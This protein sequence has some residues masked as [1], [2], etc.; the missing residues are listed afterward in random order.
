MKRFY[1]LAYSV[2]P[3]LIIILVYLYYLS[4]TNSEQ[5]REKKRVIKNFENELKE[6][7]DRFEDFLTNYINSDDDIYSYWVQSDYEGFKEVLESRVVLGDDDPIK[8][9]SFYDRYMIKRA[10]IVH[11]KGISDIKQSSYLPKVYKDYKSCSTFEYSK[12]NGLIYSSI[13]PVFRGNTL[14]YVLEITYDISVILRKVYNR[15]NIY[16]L[17]WVK[18][19]N[20]NDSKKFIADYTISVDHDSKLHINSYKDKIHGYL[21]SDENYGIDMNSIS[22]F[23]GY[24]TK[25]ISD[26]SGIYVG[27]FLFFKDTEIDSSFYLIVVLVTIFSTMLLLI[28][29]Y[30]E[31][32]NRL[33]SDKLNRTLQL[34]HDKI[35]SLEE[36][37]QRLTETMF[38]YKELSN[39]SF[40]AIIF[41]ENAICVSA[42][43][44]AAKYFG[45][46]D[47]E[48]LGRNI[49]KF[50]DS[51]Y[52]D[53]VKK[54]I[55]ENNENPY[56]IE[57]RRKDGSTF[58]AHVRGRNIELKGKTLRI[59]AI[60]D[61]DQQK[62]NEEALRKAIEFSEKANRAKSEFL[63]N[64]S[65]EVRTPMNQVI[66]F[67]DIL[68]GSLKSE[69]DKEYVRN[70][71]GGG[72]KLLSIIDDIIYLSKL[73][74]SRI[75]P[76]NESTKL[77]AILT[78]THNRYKS[79]ADKKGV[80]LRLDINPVLPEFLYLDRGL[81]TRMINEF[82]SNGVKYTE[83]GYVEVVVLL[84]RVDQSKIDFKLIVADSGIGISEDRLES[85]FLP[86]NSKDL[87]KGSHTSGTG[88]GLAIAKKLSEL[89]NF[90]MEVKS[91]VGEGTTFTINFRSIQIS[92]EAE[93]QSTT[94]TQ[95]DEIPE[96]KPTTILIV[97]D[98]DIN[99][100]LLSK[101]L[102]GSSIS[103]VEASN[104]REGIEKM[105]QIRPSLTLLDAKMPVMDGFE[106]IKEIRSDDE[107]KD[108]KVILIT[109][110]DEDDIDP[111][112]CKRFDGVL[113]K[114]ILKDHLFNAFTKFLE[115][116]VKE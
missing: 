107:I 83:S 30:M 116:H 33:K 9:V 81:V 99:I 15:T 49:I 112:I 84:E 11:S 7:K 55:I 68:L 27:T 76:K 8:S 71:K 89:L 91:K 100:K 90:D 59:T 14:V 34:S 46:T 87:K 4:V 78:D 62:Q 94:T 113:N 23:T 3:L 96:F 29:R 67:S 24:K 102:D 5:N 92:E 32:E 56:E 42:N 57:C 45:L 86:F 1:R 25:N 103:Y 21:Y 95:M 35:F 52:V 88:V 2:V 73:E 85:I 51:K 53:V 54:S 101:Y 19:D 104:G 114:P 13:I 109:A 47:E 31:S 44:A 77:K 66:G 16:T 43:N 10:E 65:H 28:V 20:A 64:I 69:T 75:E 48:V 39:A 12:S 26:L 74:S 40:E 111:K 38:N 41:S 115:Y 79:E 97:D 110:S 72:N 36:E 37:L 105:K 82:V 98:M 60:R 80:Q 93:T 108:S 61:I 18:Q 22:S 106:A 50:V 63:A 17:F 58:H 70:I 6:R